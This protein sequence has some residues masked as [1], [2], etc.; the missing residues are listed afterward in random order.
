MHTKM[1]RIVIL[2]AVILISIMLACYSTKASVPSSDPDGTVIVVITEPDD[3]FDPDAPRSPSVIPLSCSLD[4][5]NGE[6]HFTF[7]LP[8]G[9]VTITLTEAVAGEVSSDDYSTSL[10]FVTVPVPAQGSYDVSIVVDNTGVE[11]I[12][13]FVL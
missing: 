9:D 1:K 8:M 3:P 12:G 5:I 11:Y 2:P 6:L 13:S 4:T 10:G 7:L